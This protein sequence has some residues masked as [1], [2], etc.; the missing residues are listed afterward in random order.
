MCDTVCS[1]P[2]N[3][4]DSRVSL[5]GKNS[6]R[7]PNEIQLVEFYP[8]SIRS[9]KTHATYID[10]EYEGKTNAVILSR[11]HWIWGAEMGVN[12]KGVSVGN[13]AIFSSPKVKSKK[14]LGMDLLRLGLEKGDDAASTAKTMIEYLETYGQGGSN[15][16]SR[17]EYYNNMFLISDLK[18]ALKLTIVEKEYSLERLSSRHSI[19]N[20]IPASESFDKAG[21]E[22]SHNFSYRED[23][24]Y[25]RLGRGLERSR[26]T[27]SVLDDKSKSTQYQDIFRMLRHHEGDWSHPSRGSNRDI[28]M[29]AGPLSR[30]F[31]TVNSFV[32][33]TSKKGTVVW[34][35]FSSNPC[36]SLYKPILF[37]GNSAFGLLYNSDYWARGE[38][39]HRNLLNSTSFSYYEF[40][41]LLDER[42]SQII[43]ISKATIDG[44]LSGDTSNSTVDESIFKTIFD[45]DGSHLSSLERRKGPLHKGLTVS[46]YDSWWKKKERSLG[47]LT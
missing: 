29:H 25:S 6:D 46:L 34:S 24:L 10:V 44:W 15:D 38:R 31:Q 45:I 20:K 26:F 17:E 9:G 2:E 35:T 47:G 40:A 18:K 28:C 30:R 5:F 37:S 41:N 39:I 12:E 16:Q 11:P 32:V 33:M 14:L 4:F 27:S 42:Q 23:I 19:S 3:N 13:E 36:I 21:L 7:D 1:L 43:D 8:R 22:R